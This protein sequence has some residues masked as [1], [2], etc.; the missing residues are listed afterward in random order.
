MEINP[1]VELINTA[2]E[3]LSK[4]DE[5]R[6][7]QKNIR[8]GSRQGFNFFYALINDKVHLEKYHT[9]FLS[10]LLCPEESHDCEGIFF[11]C[12]FSRP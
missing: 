3:V 10:Y 9:S 8:R 6:L 7:V 2:C 4:M 12:N 5:L 1:K 11:L